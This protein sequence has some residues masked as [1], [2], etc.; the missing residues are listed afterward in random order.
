MVFGPVVDDELYAKLFPVF[1]AVVDEFE[2]FA[3]SV[4]AAEVAWFDPAVAEIHGEA[5]G[6]VGGLAG[7]AFDVS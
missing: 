5:A 6:M 1:E 4:G 7:F 2:G 3:A